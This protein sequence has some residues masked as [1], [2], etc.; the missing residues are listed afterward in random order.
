MSP[1][2]KKSPAVVINAVILHDKQ[3]AYVPGS[4][5]RGHFN[6]FAGVVF[7]VNLNYLKETQFESETV[8]NSRV[9]VSVDKE[10]R[11]QLKISSCD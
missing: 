4:D 9:I 7:I 1:V 8:R 5:I 10:N 6:G 11:G 2:F 3:L